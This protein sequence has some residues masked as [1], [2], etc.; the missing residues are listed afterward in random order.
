MGNLG[1]PE[2]MVILVVA[3]IFFG[4]K[5]LPEIGKSLGK[6]IA[7]FKKATNDFTRKWNEDVETE[8]KPDSPP[9]EKEK[10]QEANAL[11][12]AADANGGGKTDGAD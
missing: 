5:K 8:K 10:P 3:L 9:E 2:L 11:H 1:F 12:S 6:G 7:E 4:P